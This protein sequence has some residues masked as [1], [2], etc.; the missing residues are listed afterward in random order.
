MILT[1]VAGGLMPGI[2]TKVAGRLMNNGSVL[3]VGVVA[4]FLLVVVSLAFP[5]LARAA[6]VNNTATQFQVGGQLR[7]IIPNNTGTSFVT[8]ACSTSGG[9]NGGTSLALVPSVSQGLTLPGVVDPVLNPLVLA[10]SCL[11]TNTTNGARLNFINPANGT[12]VTQISTHPVPS[13]GYPH[14][15]F[16]P[17]KGDLLVCSESGALYSIVPHQAT[18][19][20]PTVPATQL[21]LQ[22]QMAQQPTS[23]KGLAWDAEADMIYMGL[24]VNGG[25]KI[26]RVVRFQEA[27]VNLLGDFTSLPC[28]ANGLAISGGVLLMSCVPQNNPQPTDP[29]MFRL[30]KNTGAVLGVFGKGTAADPSFHPP[31]GLGDLACDP[32]TF[33]KDQTGKDVFTDGLWSRLGSNGNTVVVLEFPAFTCGLPSSSVV[34]QGMVSYS[35]LAAGLSA[36]GPNGPPGQLP[37]SACF[38]AN[39]K[40][41][42]ADGDGLPD[43]WE[44]N[45][46]GSG[47]GTDPLCG[48]SEHFCGGIDF[49]GTCATTGCTPDLELCA[50]VDTNG[51][52]IPDATECAD[53]NH[54]DLFVE[55]A[56]MQY[57]KPDPQALSQTQSVRT[58]GVKSVREAFA[59]A[60][61]GNPD[62]TTGINIH[63]R[64]DGAPVTFTNIN[65][66]STNHACYVALTP[67]TGTA[68]TAPNPPPTPPTA[69]CLDA[70]DVAADYDSI[71][72][73]N[74]GRFDLAADP[75]T[76]PKNPPPLTSQEL[77]A[78][79]LAVR[80]VL[81]AHNLVGNPN[82]GS[83]SSGCSEVGGDD[84]VVSL[85]S[86]VSTTVANV[87]H[88]R[89]TTDQQAGTFMHEFGHLLGL[90]HGGADNVNCKPNYRSV[91]SY[92][93]QF[94]GSPIPNRRLDYSRSLDPLIIPDPN[95][96]KTGFLYEGGLNEFNGLGVDPSL[97]PIP[98]RNP[99]DAPFFPSADQIVFG[100][101]AWSL[102]PGATSTNS[103]PL[104][105][106]PP[107]P[108]LP[109][110]PVPIN[111]DRSTQGKSPS[112]QN[113]VSVDISAGATTGC[114]T[115]V[116]PQ[117]LEGSND[118]ANLL[119]RFSAAINFAGG[120]R[121]AGLQ[122]MTK[123]QETA[124]FLAKD[125]DGNGASDGTDCGG[126]VNK[127]NGTTSCA[128]THRIDIKPSFPVPKTIH[129]G[130]EA[131]VTIAIFS[132][133]CDNR[134]GT[135]NAPT[136]VMLTD[137]TH[138]PLTFT[139]ESV[140][141]PVK[142]NN[143]G[144]GTC[145]ASN[146]PDPSGAD[147]GIKDLKCQFSTSGLPTGTHFGIVSGYFSDPL[148]NGQI[149]AFEARQEMT[150][151]P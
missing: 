124:A 19:T 101:G 27:S 148:T 63:I 35:P 74:F 92:P 1:K 81:F 141:E 47:N 78:K 30:D 149:R 151:L 129:L 20:P 132:E 116:V 103:A 59:A 32:V 51:D 40:V 7:Q 119:Y 71:K 139:V 82:G 138:F 42:D 114:D 58:V 24:S 17:D 110:T 83:S 13:T 85:G 23:C 93:R 136:Q 52:G 12:V 146:V 33:Q 4:G 34:I 109:N 5:P 79:R 122:E 69:T 18:G 144:Q 104:W 96:P 72:A 88:N 147:D 50:D 9:A 112:F 128:C 56:W 94:A 118:W 150:I 41:K 140:V 91:M 22:L 38:D 115:S 11:D 117:V 123:E 97:G 87:S 43:C 55:A 126:T 106:L 68:N 76:D 89:G 142:V 107:P 77:N 108:A 44:R 84:A 25:N 62:G 135:W 75:A 48:H 64:V 2:L 111:W 80:N 99:G 37:L 39:G 57:H 90:Q 46:G 120:V 36:P 143:K 31:A 65:N 134:N 127:I 10:V 102:V 15:V 66:I 14:S 49:G 86:F 100:P 95:P 61:V 3:S 28:T 26:G 60:P 131:N 54:K 105:P 98:G 70:N 133:V 21:T 73:T 125:V 6:W 45:Q 53:P 16:R 29:T 113:N 145:A 137:L 67:C 8:P 130:T 121:S